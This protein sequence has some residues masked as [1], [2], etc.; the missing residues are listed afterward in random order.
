MKVFMIN[1][2]LC[3]VLKRKTYLINALKSNSILTRNFSTASF[4]VIKDSH[5]FSLTT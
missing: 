1:S 5:I 4:K 3:K 2:P